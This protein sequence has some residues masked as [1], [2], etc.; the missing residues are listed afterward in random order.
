MKRNSNH[1]VQSCVQYTTI[2]MHSLETLKQRNKWLLCYQILSSKNNYTTS[3]MRK[4]KKPKN[5]N[6][7]VSMVITCIIS[8][9]TDL[10]Y[11]QYL[12][13]D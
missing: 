2:S 1:D 3:T 7:E 5:N 13:S 11:E 8:R 9:E 10:K 4:R 12:H 6:A